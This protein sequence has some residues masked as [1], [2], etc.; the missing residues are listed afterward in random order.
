MKSYK[1]VNPVIIGSF[2]TSFNANDATSAAET[3]WKSLSPYITNNVP[4]FMFTLQE[5]G[6][7]HHFVVKESVRD[8]S[9]FADYSLDKINI[10]M[11]AK[12]QKT[13]LDKVAKL[14]SMDQSGGK[15]KKR[16]EEDDS[17]S[18]SSDSDDD[19][20]NF[21]HLRKL[22]QPILYWSY[23]PTIYNT[24]TTTYTPTFNVPLTPYT[25]LWWVPN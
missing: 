24:T 14:S 22:N 9:K 3:F 16:Y 18:S 11:S 6:N 10:T 1:L 17:S 25:Q 8:G 21:A 12:Q 19:Y 4:K 20:F 7:L 5:G 23:T 13:F 15:R 2:E